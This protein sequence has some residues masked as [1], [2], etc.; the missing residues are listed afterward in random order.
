MNRKRQFALINNLPLIALSGL[1]P[2]VTNLP[3][4]TITFDDQTEA[5]NLHSNGFS[6]QAGAGPTGIPIP[7]LAACRT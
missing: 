3:A 4:A 1:L 5:A 6:G 2:F 7:A